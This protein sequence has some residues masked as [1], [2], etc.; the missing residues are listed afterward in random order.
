MAAVFMDEHCQ[1]AWEHLLT[2]YP[3]LCFQGLVSVCCTVW[4][5]MSHFRPGMGH[6]VPTVLDY[7]LHVCKYVRTCSCQKMFHSKCCVDG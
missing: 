6:F 1:E 2:V 7:R 3:C 5:S 4:C